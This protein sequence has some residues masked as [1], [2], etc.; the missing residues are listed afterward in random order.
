MYLTEIK[1]FLSSPT[2]LPFPAPLMILPFNSK[3]ISDGEVKN[4]ITKNS[5]SILKMYEDA[6]VRSE[7]NKLFWYLGK[8]YNVTFD[9][10]VTKIIFEDNNIICHDE[11]SL[12][13]FYNLAK[14]D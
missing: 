9:N 7:R 6:L 10:R 5:S 11:E 14:Q 2:L 3:F 1:L 13:K 8:G 4:L 12:T